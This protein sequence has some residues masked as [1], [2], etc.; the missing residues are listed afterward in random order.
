MFT[1]LRK[2]EAEHPSCARLQPQP[3]IPMLYSVGK[4]KLGHAAPGD[5]G[6]LSLQASVSAHARGHDVE[7]LRDDHLP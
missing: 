7:V 4:D 5:E 6:V 1:H 3:R 2:L